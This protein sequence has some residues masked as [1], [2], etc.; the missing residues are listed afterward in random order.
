MMDAAEVIY[1]L[2]DVGRHLTM[3]WSVNG[4]KKRFERRQGNGK[5]RVQ[6]ADVTGLAN[7]IREQVDGEVIGIAGQWLAH[8]GRLLALGDAPLGDRIDWHR[9][10]S[11]GKIAPVRYSGLINHSDVA[12]VGNIKYIWELNRL[13]HLV[14]LALAGLSTGNGGYRQE[15]E[16]QI[17]SWSRENPFMRGVNWKSPLE[18]GIRLISWAY[19]SFL[20]A[21]VNGGKGRYQKALQETIYQHQ[22]FIRKFYSKHS[23][24]NNHLIG[25][26][27]GM[28][29]DDFDR[30]RYVSAA[31]RRRQAEAW[32]RSAAMAHGIEVRTTD[33]YRSRQVA[34]DVRA[35]FQGNRFLVGPLVDHVLAR[36]P[37]GPVVDLYSGVGLFGLSL[38]GA[39][40][41]GVIV[42]EGDPVS[43]ADLTA[44]SEPFGER[45]RVERRS[46]EQFV[47][48]IRGRKDDV[49]DA[50]MIVDP[51][52]T[53]MTK[54]AL[55]GVV[56]LQPARVVYVSCDVATLARD[57]RVLLDAGY[58]LNDLTGID[59]FPNTAHVESVAVF[60]R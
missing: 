7:R 42:V 46:V 55:G 14:L 52:R 3:W 47:A 26:M 59:L 45:V 15:I 56:A 11:S 21:E 48:L 1:R 40:R 9:D 16:R 8:R 19:V 2:A 58:E 28:Y 49:T 30:P 29:Y 50:T 41:A 23:S 4:A 54:E 31:E 27:A 6:A 5:Q 60:V 43:A 32:L 34:R 38:A 22:Y 25:E 35:F 33:S 57:T 17:D 36:V 20:T 39:R 44:N 53:G 13:Q 18:A 51:P 10:Y 12:K 37:E 24:A